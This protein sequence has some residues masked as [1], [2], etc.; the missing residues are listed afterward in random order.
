MCR[1]PRDQTTSCRLA[2]PTRGWEA[3]ITALSLAAVLATVTPAL[4]RDVFGVD[5]TTVACPA[6]GAPLIVPLDEDGELIAP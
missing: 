6:T 3:A 4:V 2:S 1:I 5:C